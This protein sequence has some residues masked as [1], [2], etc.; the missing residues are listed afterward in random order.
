MAIKLLDEAFEGSETATEFVSE[1]QIGDD[2]V[3]ERFLGRPPLYFRF[4]LF[5]FLFLLVY[6]F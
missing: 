3:A 5:F 1:D 2:V 6:F 4:I